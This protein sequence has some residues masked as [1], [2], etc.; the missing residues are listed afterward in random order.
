MKP[1]HARGFT[2]IEALLALAIFAVIAVLSYR[3]TASMAEGEAHLSAEAQRWR[4][5][6]SLFTRFEADIRQAVPRSARVGAQ[7]EAAWVGATF[8]GHAA[9]AFTRA[10]SEFVLEPG[11]SGQRLGYRL[12][13][14]MLELVYWPAIDHEA[15]A[16][17]TIY[18]MVN[19]VTG[20]D[21]AYLHAR[22]VARPLA[23]ARRGR[24]SAGG[25]ADAHARRRLAHGPSVSH[26][27]DG[28]T[29]TRRRPH[30]R[31]ARRGAWQATVA[32]ALAA[33]QQRWLAGRRQPP[34]PRA[35]AV[36]RARG[37]AW[38][39]QIL[40]D[41]AR[42]GTVD[43]LGEPWS[44]PLPPT[45]IADGTV[46]GRIEDAQGRLNLNNAA[47]EGKA[48][49]AEARA[50][51]ATVRGERCRSPHARCARGLDRRR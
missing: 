45:P 21:L 16:K 23:L 8:D 33:D 9:I 25:E 15:A 43:F 30:P 13:G 48:G 39:R 6:E 50:P 29:A 2:L 22:T 51:H 12:N 4:T 47:Q 49:D 11:A 24:S 14:S 36:A 28:A 31:D 42:A 19:G 38:A 26:C 40:A 17:P 44:Y 46:E 18:P 37:R 32:V 27:D 20:F 10:G 1:F 35:G 5:L 7:R 34:R 3:A 41:D